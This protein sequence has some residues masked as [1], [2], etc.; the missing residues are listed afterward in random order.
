MCYSHLQ[1]AQLALGRA[2]GGSSTTL[3]DAE[4]PASE[5]HT[6]IIVLC[7][8]APEYCRNAIVSVKSR[9]RESHSLIVVD[10]ASDRP[11]KLVLQELFADGMID[12]LVF[13]RDNL[14]FAAGNNLAVRCCPTQATHVLL[15]N[16]DIEVRANCWLQAMLS[17]HETGITSLGVANGV[18]SRAEGY[19]FLI[20]RFLYERFGLDESM[21]WWWSTTKLQAQV[22]NANYSV[23]AVKHHEELL[24]H[25]GGGSGPIQRYLSESES[26]L[27]IPLA[28]VKGWFGGHTIK[29]LSEIECTP[30]SDSLPA[31]N[32]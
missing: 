31:K 12:R 14:F 20:D 11:T 24:Y 29:V 1:T 2:D 26:G 19:C 27:L 22:L 7:H 6:A 18:L 16:S 21:P 32:R 23:K 9:T 17:V 28:E 15:L 25:E 4:T 30:A 5:V 10:N 3:M 13:S 8:N